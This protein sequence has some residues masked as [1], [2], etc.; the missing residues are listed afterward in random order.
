MTTGASHNQSLS[1]I[2]RFKPDD[3]GSGQRRKRK[4]MVVPAAN[5]DECRSEY[6]VTIATPG[7]NKKGLEV[8]IHSGLLFISAKREKESGWVHDRWEYDYSSWQRVFALPSDAE[9][10]MS[11]ARYENGE[12]IITIPRGKGEKTRFTVPVQVY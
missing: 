7:F 1:R 4:L 6:R 9:A 5:V 12:L 3:R 11:R 10:L 8:K 2:A